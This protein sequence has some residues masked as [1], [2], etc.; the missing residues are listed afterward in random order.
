LFLVVKRCITLNKSIDIDDICN[1][2]F[3]WV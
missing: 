2:F 3:D 1:E